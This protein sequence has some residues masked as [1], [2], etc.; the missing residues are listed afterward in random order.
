MVI[1]N[2]SLVTQKA[3]RGALVGLA[4]EAEVASKE[5][6]D[7]DDDDVVRLKA[8]AASDVTNRKRMLGELLAEAGPELPG[9]ERDQLRTLLLTNH[10]AF[11][12]EEG[13]RGETDLVQMTIDTGDSSPKHQPVR[14]MPFAVRQQVA[15]QLKNMQEQGVTHSHSPWAMLVRKRMGL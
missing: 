2:D 3:Q 1:T 8:V 10:E 9:Q 11:A 12:V 6:E 13:E 14:R 15:E 4:S 7:S 5:D